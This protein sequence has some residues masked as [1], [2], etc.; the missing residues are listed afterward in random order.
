M[1][2]I[3]RDF[4]ALILSAFIFLCFGSA[5]SQ[6]RS[7]LLKD[8]RFAKVLVDDDDNFTNVGN[9]SLTVTNYGTFGDGFVSQTPIDQPSCEYPKGSAIEHIFVGGLWVGGETSQGIRV[10]TGAFNISSLSGGAGAAN[11][12]FTNTADLNDLISERSSLPANA[13]Y[14]PEAISHQ[15]F[16][17]DFVDTNTFIPGTAIQIP[18]HQPLGLAVHMETYAWNFPFAD[19]FVILNYT[20]TNLSDEPI[21]NTYVGLWADLVVRNTNNISPRVGGPFY[22]D[23][24][25]GFMN[26]DTAKMIYAYEYGA[27]NYSNADSYVAMVLLGGET[28]SGVTYQNEMINNWWLF[29]GGDAD[30]ERAPADEASKY[31]RMGEAIANEAINNQPGNYMNL[32]S[33]GPF[34][35]IPAGESINAVFAIVCG[36]KFG[37]DPPRFDTINQRKNLLENVSWAQRAY[38][39]EDSNRNGILDF[40]G[41]DSTEDVNG[42]GR[43]DRYILPTPPSPPNLK[44]IPGNRKVVLRWDDT[45]EKS[46]DL[47]SKERDFEGYRIYRS[48]LGGEF[49]GQGLFENMQ[50][51]AE[52]DR[53]DGR[54]YDSGLDEALMAELITEIVPNLQTG[55]NDTITYRYELEIDN[56]LNGWQYAFAISAFDSGDVELNLPS[57]ESSRLQNAVVVSPGT[58]VNNE[59]DRQ[60]GVYPNPYRVNAL[61][62]GGLERQRKLYFYN[63]PQ[64][65]EVR[66]YTLAGDQV[67]SFVHNGE[68]YTGDDI[69]WYRQFSE[70]KTVFAGGEHAW[71]LV[72]EADQ[73]IATG[74][75]L[76]TVKDLD[77]GDVYRGKFMIIK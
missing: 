28:P 5:F 65:C 72:T 64:N 8:P 67:G 35:S 1:Q 37:G 56:L 60:I 41:T 45:A 66:I 12:E 43:L 16:V 44:V 68:A 52:Y 36:R 50:L 31:Q 10:T 24:G 77:G 19:D 15:D 14:S 6:D 26:N 3:P 13:F 49:A 70:G 73:A 23:V 20:I 39:G 47:I 42:N 51:I 34:S 30:W 59:A 74:L 21:N 29:S 18:N 55:L 17:A 63:L 71:D 62:D 61:W 4:T 46:V 40:A 22:S 38:H 25:I 53:I 2:K 27:N 32:I 75:Y 7:P 57:L 48:F 33:T 11:F 9:I 76:F 58:P 69:E 54:F